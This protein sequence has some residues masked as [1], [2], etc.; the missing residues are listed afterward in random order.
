MHSWTSPCELTKLTNPWRLG[1]VCSKWIAVFFSMRSTFWNRIGIE[2][3][4]GRL[5]QQDTANV[6]EIVHVFPDCTRGAPFSYAFCMEGY[7]TGD[8]T[9]YDTLADLINCSE[10]WEEWEEA[11]TNLLSTELAFLYA[12]KGRPSQLKKMEIDVREDLQ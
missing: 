6:T 5:K 3:Y 4:D 1:H 7:C 10:Q 8:D 9:D 2:W 12:T 11:S